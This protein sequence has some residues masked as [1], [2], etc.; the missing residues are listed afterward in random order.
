MTSIRKPST[1]RSSHQ[2]IIV[3]DRRPDLRVLPV[4]VG[5]LP[6]EQVQVVL[7]R[8]PA[9]HSQAGPEKNDPQLLG[10]APGGPRYGAG[11]G[12]APD[13]PVGLRVDAVAP[14]LLEPR[15]LV[16]GVVDHE[17]HDQPHAALVDALDQLVDVGQRPEGR[18]DVLVVADVVAVVVLRRPVDRRQPDDVDAQVGDVVEVVDDAADVA[19]AVA[20]GVGEAARVDLVDDRGLPPRVGRVGAVGGGG[21]GGVCPV[22]Q[23]PVMSGS[24][25]RSRLRRRVA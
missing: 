21:M 12:V 6:R 16:G 5:L 10:S 25:R 1:P 19:D 20:V 23:R 8:A 3:V 13:V 17:V 18:V 4:E 24:G 2:R 11:A 22:G 7:L 15:V 14:R 9:H